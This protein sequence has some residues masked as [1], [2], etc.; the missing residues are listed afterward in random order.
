[1]KTSTVSQSMD[2][3]NNQREHQRV[4]SV[5]STPLPDLNQLL[6]VGGSHPTSND[7]GHSREVTA[8]QK[9]NQRRSAFSVAKK[10]PPGSYVGEDDDDDDDDDDD[11]DDNDAYLFN[12]DVGVADTSEQADDRCHR[13]QTSAEHPSTGAGDAWVV[14]MKDN[15]D[16]SASK[17]LASD[18]SQRR[19]RKSDRYSSGGQEDEATGQRKAAAVTSRDDGYQENVVDQYSSSTKGSVSEPDTLQAEH[20]GQQIQVSPDGN[21]NQ[22]SDDNQANGPLFER[23]A[24]R[25]RNYRD[26]SGQQEEN[27]SSF[28]GKSTL[29]R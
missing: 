5:S 24:R 21:N 20:S 27:K 17:A 29:P 11:G 9:D 2:S 1:M 23:M 26:T 19:N 14:D 7:S 22:R 28:S 4:R 6:S 13:E 10:R 16:G 3:D 25:R 18:R 15:T 8:D 12:G